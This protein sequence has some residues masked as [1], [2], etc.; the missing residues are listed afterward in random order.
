MYFIIFVAVKFKFDM[1]NF[2][3][4]TINKYF[5]TYALLISSIKFMLKTFKVYYVLSYSNYLIDINIE[6]SYFL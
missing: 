1:S 5:N 3:N 6:R 2:V 4:P